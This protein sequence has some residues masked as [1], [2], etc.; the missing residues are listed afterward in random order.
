MISYSVL[1]VSEDYKLVASAHALE[2]Y[3]KA[4]SLNDLEAYSKLSKRKFGINSIHLL[5]T[6]NESKCHAS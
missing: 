1:F 4:R 2:E 6:Q 5:C 3:T